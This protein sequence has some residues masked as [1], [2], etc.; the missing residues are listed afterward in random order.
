[1]PVTHAEGHQGPPDGPTK[2]TRRAAELRRT[3]SSITSS[4]AREDRASRRPSSDSNQRDLALAS[5]PGVAAACEEIVAD[6]A[7]AFRDTARGNL[8]AV[9][10]QRH[11]RLGLGNHGPARRQAGDG[12]QGP[13]SSRSSPDTTCSTSS[14]TSPTRQARRRHRRH[15]ATLRRH[16]PRGHQG[17]RLLLRERKL[18]ERMKI[19][20]L[21]DPTQHGTAIVV[22]A[23]VWNGLKV[24]ASRS[25][26][27]KLGVSGAGRQR[28]PA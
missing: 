18:R 6:P 17:A 10:N 12:R 5:S 28:S 27:V 25:P 4:D 9:V 22:G 21:H 19:P 8:V 14:S 13:C 24:A 15:R 20:V 1:M 11:R 26:R 3:R 7:N 23:G 16:Q 2:K